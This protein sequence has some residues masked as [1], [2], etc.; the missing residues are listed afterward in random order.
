MKLNAFTALFVFLFCSACSYSLEIPNSFD[1]TKGSVLVGRGGYNMNLA[2]KDALTRRGYDLIVG[3]NP[4]NDLFSD[5]ADFDVVEYDAN[6][7]RYIVKVKE[8][9]E[10]FAPIT[11]VFGGF[12][13]WRFNVSISDNKTQK[14]ILAWSGRGCADNMIHQLNVHL[15]NI[16]KN[17]D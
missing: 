5:S 3:K 14:E 4:K 10:I 11:C 9:S 13:R 17:A 16:E 1:K 7:V 15:D 2:V 8:K 6:K 12:Y